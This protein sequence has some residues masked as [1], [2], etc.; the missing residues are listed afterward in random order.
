MESN[1]V[2]TD[3]NQSYYR[4]DYSVAD[5]SDFES[6]GSKS[7]G[8]S[9]RSKDYWFGEKYF[10]LAVARSV[11]RSKDSLEFYEDLDVSIGLSL[12]HV[13]GDSLGCLFSFIVCLERCYLCVPFL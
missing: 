12:M 4:N 11:L 3:T 9:L 6:L 7:D 5:D 1:P 10:G 13:S 2:T 8:M